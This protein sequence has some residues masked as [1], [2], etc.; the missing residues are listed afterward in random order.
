MPKRQR[1]GNDLL[2]L[3][4]MGSDGEIHPLKQIIKQPTVLVFQ[5]GASHADQ[6]KN[7]DEALKQWMTIPGAPGCTTQIKK[8]NDLREAFLQCGWELAVIMSHKTKTDLSSIHEQQKLLFPIYSLTEESIQDLESKKHPCFVFEG[9]TYPHRWTCLVND[10]GEISRALDRRNIVP[11]Q[12]PGQTLEELK[13]LLE[14][15][16]LYK[17]T[18]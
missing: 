5:P 13:N 18:K 12:E 4:V 6:W 2:S 7:R 9:K 11:M 14:P 10:D 17:P 8:Y 1:E 15:E 16:C 3:K